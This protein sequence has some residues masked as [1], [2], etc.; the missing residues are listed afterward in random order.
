MQVVNTIQAPAAPSGA[1]PAPPL[2]RVEGLAKAF[3]PTRALRSCSFEVAAGEVHAIVGEN[4]SG[5]STLVKILSGVHSPDAGTLA[6]AG[7]PL[8]GRRSP[9]SAQA[10]GIVTVFQEVLVVGSQSVVEN[11]WLGSDGLFRRTLDQRR[12]RE[13]ASDVLNMLLATPPAL[14]TPAESLSLSDRQACCIARALVRSP[15]VLILDESTSALDVVT[16]DRLF[17]AVRRLCGAGAAV[18]FIS[19]RMGEIDE[20]ANRVTVLRS[21]ESV[22]TLARHE[23]TS[24]VLVRHMTGSDHLTSGAERVASTRGG[25]RASETPLIRARG[26]RLLP[27]AAPIDFDLHAG[28]IVGLAGL[29][30]HGQQAFL[31]ALRGAGALAGTVSTADGNVLRSPRQAIA[32]GI[33]YV[34]R[35]RRDESLFPSLSINENFAAPTLRADSRGGI[36]FS[37]RSAG[38]LSSYVKQLAIRLGSQRQPITV[39]S[40]G[41]QQKVIVARWLAAHPRVLLLNDPTRGVDLAAK[42]DLYRLLERLIDEGVGVV[43]LSTEL[44]ELVELMDRVLV[45]REGAVSA[46]VERARLSRSALVA[47]FFGDRDESETDHRAS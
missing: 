42:R 44:D 18:I 8:T 45:F 46:E 30:G 23:T 1:R 22:A 2:L 26:L 19:H 27:G 40:G 39:L 25:A 34:P 14:D 16:R 24:E 5:K 4:G 41:N 43:M 11:I 7:E 47:H 31:N 28:E 20:L 13:L 36:V 9:R 10:A 21:G 38:R 35:D 33:A 29:E 3:G 32:E 12:K 6:L 17:A 15:R 37:R